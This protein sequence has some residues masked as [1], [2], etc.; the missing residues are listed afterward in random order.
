MSTKF[1]CYLLSLSKLPL[2]SFWLELSQLGEGLIIYFIKIY[3]S[4]EML[5]HA[6][7]K[8]SFCLMHLFEIVW[9]WIW[10]WFEI[11]LKSIEKNK[12]KRHSK[13]QGKRKNWIKHIRPN[14]AQP[15]H[16]RARIDWQVGPTCQRRP[17]P[18]SLSL[19]LP[20]GT[21]LSGW[22]WDGY[23]ERVSDTGTKTGRNFGY[24]YEYFVCRDGYGY[25]PDT[26]PR[27]YVGYG[28]TNTRS[29]P[30]NPGSDTGTRF[31]FFCII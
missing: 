4:D 21:G 24:G 12:K 17:R 9:I 28:I 25:Y 19:P 26:E 5:H 13:F 11:D 29:V 7:P 1:K 14:L 6:E 18:H 2:S 31:F 15:G 10:I 8:L 20:C 23:P 30:E 3:V 27:I 16:G 22:K